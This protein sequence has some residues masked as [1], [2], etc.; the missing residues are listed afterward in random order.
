MCNALIQILPTNDRVSY[1]LAV[2]DLKKSSK[3]NANHCFTTLS[4]CQL[5][6]CVNRHRRKT[7]PREDGEQ[8]VIDSTL[9]NYFLRGQKLPDIEG[10]NPGKN[11]SWKKCLPIFWRLGKNASQENFLLQLKL[12]KSF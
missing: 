10:P 3:M 12:H 2:K 1:C 9:Y 5:R 7:T 11:A 6:L 8:G 4:P